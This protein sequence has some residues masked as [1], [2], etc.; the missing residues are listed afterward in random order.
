MAEYKDYTNI[1]GTPFQPYVTQQIEKR[2]ELIKKENRSP[3][4]LQWLTNKNVWIR[5][6]SGADVEEN[7]A[8]F[9][10][11]GEV[12]GQKLARKYILQGGLFKDTSVINDNGSTQDIKTLREG[13]GPDGAYGIGGNDFGYRPMPGL[14]NLSIKTGGK[15]GTLREATFD[16]TCYN[17]KQLD[18]MSALYMRLGFGVLIEWGHIPFINN[19]GRL[20]T[21][22]LPL[23]FF[24][25]SNQAGINDKEELLEKIQSQRVAHSGNYDA[26]WGTIKNFSYSLEDNGTFKCQVQ[27]VGAGDILESLKINQSG[28]KSSDKTNQTEEDKAIYATI[29]SREKSDLNKALYEYYKKVT[30]INTSSYNFNASVSFLE[31]VEKYLKP[32]LNI[33]FYLNGNFF[34]WEKNDELQ[35]KGYHYSLISK[36]N[37]NNGNTQLTEIPDIPNPQYFFSRLIVGYSINGNDKISNNTTEPGLEQ[38]YITLGHLLLLIKA[39]G[40]L[41]DKNQDQIKPYIYIDVNPETNRCYTFP[42]HC[43]LDPTVCLIG[44]QELPFKIK[45]SQLFTLLQDKYPFYDGIN[46]ELG[47]R[48]MQTLVNIEFVTSTLKKYTKNKENNI[49]FVDFMKDILNSISK[50]CGGFNEFRIV[51]DDNSNCI[52]IFDDRTMPGKDVEPNKYIKIPV[53]GKN[54][55]VYNFNYTS[56]ISPQMATQIVISAQAQD[57]GIN[58]NKDA[59]A[60]S[61]LNGGLKN[62]LVSSRVESPEEENEDPQTSSLSTYIE[63]RSHLQGIYDG[64]GISLVTQEDFDIV[65]KESGITP[66]GIQDFEELSNDDQFLRNYLTQLCEKIVLDLQEAAENLTP[67]SKDSRDENKRLSDARDEVLEIISGLNLIPKTISNGVFIKINDPKK[68]TFY[69]RLK[70]QNLYIH[71]LLKSKYEA[72]NGEFSPDTEIEAAWTKIAQEQTGTNGSFY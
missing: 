18:I 68:P 66:E 30:E 41:Y 44:S 40:W 38:A 28:N 4:D 1:A 14:T 32:K 49:Y 63:L 39:T 67:E 10:D 16:F 52:R 57:G 43:S 2:K 15:L 33:S 17:K 51:P 31:L 46:P 5:I 25:N 19:E 71:D 12:K 56:K 61:H 53:L 55:I 48:F 72:V 50:A 3:S 37:Q 29:S 70:S 54:S 27:L 23:S 11:L 42:G 62:R 20:E 47:G 7:N 45:N 59:L 36:L 60:F 13:I 6:S 21:N 34:N 9:D 8:D 58:T 24:Q 22:P 35:R 26:L 65:R 64:V 69:S